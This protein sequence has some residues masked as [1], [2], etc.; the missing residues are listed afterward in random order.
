MTWLTVRGSF[1]TGTFTL[2]L[3]AGWVVVAVACASL[4]VAVIRCFQEVGDTESSWTS[5][6]ECLQGSAGIKATVHVQRHS[7][8][9]QS[10]KVDQSHKPP[11]IPV[12]SHCWQ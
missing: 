11:L 3:T 6:F 2:M 9:L 4:E 1:V 10:F 12:A 8:T 7:E 5:S